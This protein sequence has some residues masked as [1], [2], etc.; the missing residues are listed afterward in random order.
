[1]E[2]LGET[3][4]TLPAAFWPLEQDPCEQFDEALDNLYKLLNPPSHVGDVEGTADERSL[5]YLTGSKVMPRAIVLVNFD[6][7]IKL[8]GLQSFRGGRGS[9][10][11]MR[12]RYDKEK[13]EDMSNHGGWGSEHQGL[14]IGDREPPKGKGKER[15][16]N[17]EA[18]HS[19]QLPILEVTD[20]SPHDRRWIWTE[21]AMYTVIDRGYDFSF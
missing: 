5:V 19:S 15:E 3:Y 7:A 2:G 12:T 18:Q 16:K 10:I 8:R 20:G 1:M 13:L 21:R 9:G 6:P 14:A 4:T 17:K 11:G